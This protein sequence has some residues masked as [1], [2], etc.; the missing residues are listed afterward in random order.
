MSK[1]FP[2]AKNML[3]DSRIWVLFGVVAAVLIVGGLWV[4]GIITGSEI[5]SAVGSISLI[6][7]F[8]LF[9]K[10]VSWEKGD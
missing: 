3:K 8:I 5:I 4:S 7:A 9:L 6:A 10:I 2:E 1:I